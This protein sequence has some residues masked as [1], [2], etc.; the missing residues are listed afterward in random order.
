MDLRQTGN[1]VRS[2]VLQKISRVLA[3]FQAPPNRTT[4]HMRLLFVYFYT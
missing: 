1:I 4:N 2:A 3:L